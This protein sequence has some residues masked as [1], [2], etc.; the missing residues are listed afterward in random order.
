[1]SALRIG[2]LG[3]SDFAWRKAIPALLKAPELKLAA[4]ASRSPEKARKFTA[5]FGG[6]PVAGYER[7][8][9]RPDVDAV[10]V[11]LPPSLHEEW[12]IRAVKAGKHAFVEKPFAMSADSGRRMVDAAA[13]AGRLL[14]EN[15]AFL[16][17]PRMAFADSAVA[18]GDIGELRVLRAAF[19]FPGLSPDNIRY[20]RTLGGGA[21]LDCGVYAAQAC[22][23]FLGPGLKVLAARLRTDPAKGVDV[24]GEVML[25]SRS[26]AVAQ[27]AFGFE[28][29][30]QCEVVLWGS[31]GRLVLERAFTPLPDQEAV[32]WVERQNTRQ[33]HRFPAE[34]QYERMFRHFADT[35]AGG[36]GFEEEYGRILEQAEL[37]EQIKKGGV[38]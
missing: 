31:T 25:E 32:V 28:H 33:E 18:R 30:Y 29:Y 9:E 23:R 1:M 35:A 3:C 38:P 37:V 2:V 4:V 10:Y 34:N 17:H 27:L 6:D 20:D 26:G 16:R 24:A 12:V 7:L 5:A 36:K 13:A 21:L 15:F 19:A 22:L 11:P 8:I 14:M